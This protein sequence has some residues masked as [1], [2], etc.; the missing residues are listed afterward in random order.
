MVTNGGILLEGGLI[1]LHIYRIYIYDGWS[2]LEKRSESSLFIDS[3]RLTLSLTG[4]VPAG[5][6]RALCHDKQQL[7]FWSNA[8]SIK[9]GF[10]PA[11][12]KFAQ[13]PANSC[14]YSFPV[15]SEGTKAGRSR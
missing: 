3:I 13:G 11:R 9:S 4:P 5:K 10:G 1:G 2:S 15:V 12:R 6:A 7:N 14:S 8:S